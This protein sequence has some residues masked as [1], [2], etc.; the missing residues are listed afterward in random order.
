M[1]VGRSGSGRVALHCIAPMPGIAF[2]MMMTRSARRHRRLF[3]PIAAVMLA[4]TVGCV[5][6]AADARPPRVGDVAPDFDLTLIDGTHVH[7]S[8]LRGQVVVLNFWATWCGPCRTELPTLDAFY[9]LR[10]TAGLRIFA[11]ATEDS[12]PERQ[13]RGLFHAMTIPAVRRMTGAYAVLGGV[14]TNYVIDRSGHIRYAE[15][16]AFDLARMNEVFIPLLREPA[17]AAPP[18]APV[19]TA[20]R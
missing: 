10:R 4:I 17:P 2:N 14:P 18:S 15:A 3:R 12:L 11:I 8:D 13:M 19:P 16:A 7:L 1:R 5:A 6:I 20:A 9:Q